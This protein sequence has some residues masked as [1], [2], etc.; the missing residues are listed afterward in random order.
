MNKTVT[1]SVLFTLFAGMAVLVLFK[2]RSPLGKSNSSFASEPQKEIT[3]IEF[4]E[5]NRKLTLEKNGEDWL[6]DGK[7]SQEKK[8]KNQETATGFL[9]KLRIGMSFL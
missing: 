4:S 6:T 1:R 3:K 5:G 2:S 9:A 8:N 7:G